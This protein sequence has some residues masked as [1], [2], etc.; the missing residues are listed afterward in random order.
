MNTAITSNSETIVYMTTAISPTGLTSVYQA[1]GRQAVGKVAVKIHS[2]E[3][4]K[5]NH[6]RP[7][8]IQGLVQLID[9]TIVE[10]NT[11]Y[12]GARADK[13]NHLKLMAERGFAAIAPIDILDGDGVMELP[14][15][16]GKQLATNEVGA[17]LARYDFLVVLSHFKGHPMGGFGGALKNTA[18]GIASS[19][20]KSLIHTGGKERSGFGMSTPTEVFTEAMA[21]AAQ[22]VHLYFNGGQNV[23]Y[24][25]VMNRL[26]VDCDCMANPAKPDMHDIGILASLDPVALDQACVDLIYSAPDGASLIERIKSRKGL[27]ILEHAVAIGLGSRQYSSVRC[28]A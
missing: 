19:Q 16:G 7:D 12:G 6:L 11:A 23:L 25:N 18:V 8:F 15:V 24:I 10:S 9:G 28:D 20:G 2:G 4:E 26:S 22:S 21:E 13:D 17:G 5:S 14:V 3:G 27:H 1:L